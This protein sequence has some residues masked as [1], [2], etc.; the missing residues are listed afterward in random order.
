MTNN[1]SQSSNENQ[2][3]LNYSTDIN[4]IDKDEDIPAVKSCF[5]FFQSQKKHP[6]NIL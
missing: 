4:N 3:N 6:G 1:L 5:G 2:E